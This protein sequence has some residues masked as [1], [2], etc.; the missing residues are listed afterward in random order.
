M[1]AHPSTDHEP[2][3]TIT[4][5]PAPERM[6]VTVSGAAD[7]VSQQA[8]QNGLRRALLQSSDGIDLDLSKV[9]FCDCSGLNVLL[10]EQRRALNEGK[11]IFLQACSPEVHR[12]LTGT[13]TLSLFATLDKRAGPGQGPNE[14]RENHGHEAPS[15]GEVDRIELAQLRRAMKTRPVIDLARGVLMA[16]FGLEP[17]DAWSVLVSVSQNTNT[18]LHK[19][20]DDLVRS[21]TGEPLPVPIRHQVAASIT[22]LQKT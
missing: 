19:V 11:S 6:L 4:M 15:S 10:S 13:G 7:I 1:S 21:V 18:K 8:L 9:N 3:L 20:A 12:I 16:T 2:P 5:E 22:E 17:E 14:D